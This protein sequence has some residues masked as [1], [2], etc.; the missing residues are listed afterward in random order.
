VRVSPEGS[1][2]HGVGGM[3]DEELKFEEVKLKPLTE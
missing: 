3:K 1:K 2:V